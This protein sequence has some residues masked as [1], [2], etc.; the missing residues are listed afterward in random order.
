M[1]CRA[2]RMKR[3]LVILGVIALMAVMVFGS[4]ASAALKSEYKLTTNVSP[5]TIWGQGAD[6]FA[7]LVRERTKGAVNI[8][9]YHNAVLVAGDQ[10]RQA[11][12]VRSGAIDMM[13]N[14]TIN[15]SPLI[16]EFNVF[17]LPFLFPSYEAVDA[18]T[19]GP[20]GKMLFDVLDRYNM[21]GLGWGENGFRE[22]TNNV[23]PIVH[24][25]DLRGLK[26]RVTVPIYVDIFR[27]LGANPVAMNWGE[28][29]TALQTRTIDGQENPIA[30]III[31]TKVYEVQK[32]LTDWH[33]SYD[34]LVLAVNKGSWNTFDAATQEI[35][36]GCAKDAMAWQIALNRSQIKDGVEFL[37]KYGMTVTHLTPAQQK[38]F[39]DRTAGVFNTWAERVNVDIVKAFQAAV[40]PFN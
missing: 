10:M 2:Q 3:N 8:K 17:A 27:A 5:A 36:R 20:G 29:F 21:V 19:A 14:S 12:M 38:V 39:R 4:M 31:P 26:I 13:L 32:F 15:I 22:L 1:T 35:I 40:A 30:G 6:K 24:P 33:Y 18:A 37:K 28:V 7:E 34:A 23:R 16:P 25:D 9:T 11:E